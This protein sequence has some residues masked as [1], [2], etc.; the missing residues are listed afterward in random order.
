MNKRGNTHV[1]VLPMG[2]GKRGGAAKSETDKAGEPIDTE[3]RH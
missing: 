1:T 3:V 2:Q